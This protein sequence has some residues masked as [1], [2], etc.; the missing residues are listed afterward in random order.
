MGEYLHLHH[1][2]GVDI[3][4]VHILRDLRVLRQLG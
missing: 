1:S 2:N 3:S 4:S